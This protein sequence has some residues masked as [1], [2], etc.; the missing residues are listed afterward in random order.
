MARMTSRWLVVVALAVVVLHRRCDTAAPHE[1]LRI[2]TF[3]I[4]DFPRDAD[5]IEAAFDEIERL[6]AGLVAVQ[7]IDD[8]RAFAAATRRRLGDAWQFVQTDVRARWDVGVVFDRRRYSLVSTAVH[9]ETARGGG[10]PTFEV[11]VAPVGGG[12]I[13]RVYVA[14]FKCCDE[15]RPLRV[16]QHAALRALVSSARGRGERVVVMGDFNATSDDDRRDLAA[17]ADAAGLVWASEPLAC[18]AFWRRDDA[19]PRSRLDHVLTWEA[20][21]AISAAGACATD[22]CETRDRCPLYVERVSDH[23]PVVTTLAR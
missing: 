19:C 2:A 23:C 15:G 1:P 6:D 10:K 3:N 11:R 12:A 5:Q 8:G 13:V 16:R 9:D 7:E 20:P 4:E 21:L 22:G 18:T 17:L 14:H